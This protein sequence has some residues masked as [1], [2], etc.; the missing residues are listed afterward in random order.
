LDTLITVSDLQW[1]FQ[2]CG[3]TAT[4]LLMLLFT[5][6]KTVCYQQCHC[7]AALPAK[8]SVFTCHM[9]DSHSVITNKPRL[10]TKK[11]IFVQ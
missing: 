7:L 10:H 6:Y 2:T 11:H 5:Q 4:N 9:Q 1:I 3:S 8:I